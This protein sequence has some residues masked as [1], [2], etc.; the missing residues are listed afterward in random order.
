MIKRTVK[1]ITGLRQRYPQRI[2]QRAGAA[3]W[4]TAILIFLFLLAI[5]LLPRGFG[6]ACSHG[7]NQSLHHDVRKPSQLQLL[8]YD[9]LPNLPASQLPPGFYNVN[10]LLPHA[11]KTGVSKLPPVQALQPS[12]T[13]PSTITQSTSQ[14]IVS[15]NSLAC[16]DPSLGTLENHY[17]RA[18]D[19]G[20]FTGGAR[21]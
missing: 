17:W 4:A 3:G 21:T 11:G 12:G 13:C 1:N 9:V 7:G 15:G 5:P 19:M 20:A 18:F 2:R 6:Q 14:A 10:G 16:S 8:P